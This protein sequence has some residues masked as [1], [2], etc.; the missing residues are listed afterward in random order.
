M[1]VPT[2]IANAAGE[3][4]EVTDAAVWG[5]SL[6]RLPIVTG[7]TYPKPIVGWRVRSTVTSQ[8]AQDTEI[9]K[10]VDFDP[11][12]TTVARTDT[13]T[14]A[15]DWRRETGTGKLVVPKSDL[16]GYEYP[17]G[18]ISA[19]ADDVSDE[20]LV[21]FG[22]LIS[23]GRAT[24]A[25]LDTLKT[26]L[27]TRD[28]NISEVKATFD[29]GAGS[30]TVN[31]GLA[32]AAP[33]SLLLSPAALVQQAYALTPNVATGSVAGGVLTVDTLPNN[34][35]QVFANSGNEITAI[36]TIASGSGTLT[37]GI[38]HITLTGNSTIEFTVQAKAPGVS[39]ASAAELQAATDTQKVPNSVELATELNRRDALQQSKLDLVKAIRAT[40]TADD[41]NAPTEKAVR[42]AIDAINNTGELAGTA[43]DVASLPAVP[44]D[45]DADTK[46]HAWVTSD[47]TDPSGLYV[48]NATFNGW[49]LAFQTTPPVA[50]VISNFTTTD[51]QYNTPMLHAPSVLDAYLRSRR[52][53]RIFNTTANVDLT[54]HPLLST[55]PDRTA[56]FIRNT[57]GA[58]GIG[59][60]HGKATVSGNYANGTLILS[61]PASINVQPGE[62]AC[63][64]WDG[65]EIFISIFPAERVMAF[66]TYVLANAF[67]PMPHD[68][69]IVIR[70]ADEVWARR[71]G[72]NNRSFPADG[73]ENTDWFV[74]GGKR[75]VLFHADNTTEFQ[76]GRRNVYPNGTDLNT[77]PTPDLVAGAE[78]VLS[79]LNAA[80][81]GFTNE[82]DYIVNEAGDAILNRVGDATGTQLVNKPVVVVW[83]DYSRRAITNEQT[84]FG[85]DWSTALKV[86]FTIDMNVGGTQYLGHAT[87]NL[88]TGVVASDVPHLPDFYGTYHLDIDVVDLATA[89]FNF[90]DVAAS[91][92]VGVVVYGNPAQIEIP[93]VD[94]QT[95][96]EFYKYINPVFTGHLQKRTVRFDSLP[97]GKQVKLEYFGVGWSAGA[98]A[99]IGFTLTSLDTSGTRLQGNVADVDD[100]AVVRSQP[101]ALRMDNA[102]ITARQP[103]RKLVIPSTTIP[104]DGI[105]DVEVKSFGSTVRDGEGQIVATVV[106]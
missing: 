16:S 24:D 43:S 51:G 65:D 29:G 76:W 96:T 28:Q 15:Q 58:S 79:T 7:T 47:A 99:N 94:G 19:I 63:L 8:S 62:I 70:S 101:W 102:V 69:I 33:F 40:G 80:G 68:A 71:T 10:K 88:K 9:A 91:D 30:F 38:A 39:Y 64:E 3:T 82:R 86:E 21:E 34:K 18:D 1:A 5:D 97:A 35:F 83:E 36:G 46:Y 74:V 85:Q 41:L 32:V 104:A 54:T 13:P 2:Q 55:Y 105:L 103:F 100:Q 67:G 37:N 44:S 27:A 6:P 49:V 12:K 66:D 81:T 42:D 4:T 59:I 72:F 48:P 31:G 77:V 73:K 87:V 23:S 53:R 95:I 78:A 45:A 98:N 92:I 17:G 56:L 84:S 26:N 50:S 14:S 93:T 20:F 22:K 90:R 60:T 89:T 11:A 25:Q 57:N 61:D 75:T 106:N 52:M